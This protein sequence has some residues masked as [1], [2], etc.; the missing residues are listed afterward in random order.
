MTLFF[1][2][3]DGTLGACAAHCDIELHEFVEAEVMVEHGM[4]AVVWW[5][6]NGVWRMQIGPRRFASD[7]T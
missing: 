5:Y 2:A 7:R 3:T 1:R 6:R 4:P